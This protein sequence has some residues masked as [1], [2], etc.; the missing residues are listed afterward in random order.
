MVKLRINLK[1]GRYIKVNIEIN[2]KGVYEYYTDGILIGVYAPNTMKDSKFL[3]IDLERN[4]TID[5]ELSAEIKDDIRQVIDEVKDSIEKTNLEDIQKEAKDNKALDGYIREIGMDR[6][7]VRKITVMDLGREKNKKEETKKGKKKDN[8]EERQTELNN[9][10]ISTPKVTKQDVNIKQEIALG[11][12]A[13]DVQSFK[14]WIGGKLPDDIQKIGVIESDEM[15]KMKDDKGRVIDN[16]STR[17][18]LVVI[19]KDGQVEPLK[20]YIPQLEQNHSSGNNPV[21]SKYQIDTN[22]EVEKDAVLSEYR[23]GN[24]IIQLDKDQGD[25]LEVNIGQYS[26]SGNNLVTTRMRDRNTTFKTDTE[27]RKAVN[28]YYNKGV[29]ASENSYKEAEEHEEKNPDCDKMNEKDIDGDPDTKSHD[30][31]DDMVKQI[32]ENDEIS[33]VYNYND[34]KRH[35]EEKMKNNEELDEQEIRNQV[36]E[37]MENSAQAE[38]E[39]PY[40]NRSN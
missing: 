6:E 39:M 2:E 32:L 40:S 28:G 19:G 9:S 7:K 35:I 10:N 4:N 21:K 20:K 17:F 5:N 8:K 30:H 26:P 1:D 33:D 13:N 12:Q 3:E 25:D 11:E 24:K 31:V 14:N 23:I 29:Y 36:E 34:V 22:G 38:H 37:E 27:T 15:S 16:S 18:A